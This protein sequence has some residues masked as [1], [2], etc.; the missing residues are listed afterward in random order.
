MPTS[1]LLPSLLSMLAVQGIDEG[2]MRLALPGART[3]PEDP[4]GEPQ[5]TFILGGV[6]ARLGPHQIL[7]QGL[8]GQDELINFDAVLHPG[9]AETAIWLTLGRFL[10]VS[11]R[12]LIDKIDK[13]TL[14]DTGLADLR[15]RNA[16][17]EAEL[18]RHAGLKVEHR[19]AALILNMH[20]L[21]GGDVL[22]LRQSDLAD[23]MQV[24]R[25]SVSSACN[26]LS[27]ARAIRL[28]R[29]AIEIVDPDIL[30]RIIERSVTPP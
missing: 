19:L 24:R 18:A 22:G 12:R 15:R 1:L 9:Q 14:I 7:S 5:V 8:A 11:A 17:L 25:A 4:R 21:G 28:R 29:G 27:D 26:A 2:D 30:R 3:L 16:A 20:D 6:A 13:G 23:L 10:T